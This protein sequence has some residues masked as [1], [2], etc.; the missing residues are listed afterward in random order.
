MPKAR[1]PHLNHEKDRHGKM[2]WYVRVRH[3]QRILISGAFGSAEFMDAYTRAVLVSPHAPPSRK[4]KHGT[5][6]H[7]VAEWKE[8]SDWLRTAPATRR[9]RENILLH[10]LEKAGHRDYG[11]IT[12]ADIRRGKEDR[13]GTPSAAN[14]FLKTM[15]ALFKWAVAE[16]KLD[17][18][19]AEGVP[20]F[21]KTKTGGFPTWT[22][23][24][25]VA[26][27]AKYPLGTRERLVMEIALNTGLRRSDIVRVGSGNVRKGV[28]DIK[29]AK[30]GVQ[31]YVPILPRL[32]EA[33]DA[34]GPQDLWVHSTRRGKLYGTAITKESLG[35][36]FR[37]WG[38]A[39]GVAK[40]L[41]GLR[42]L[43][44]TVIADEGAS[45]LE[46]QALFGWITNN[47][48]AVYTREANKKRLA[49]Q[50]AIRLMEAEGFGDDDDDEDEDENSTIR[51]QGALTL[52]SACPNLKKSAA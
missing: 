7:L 27:R 40:R 12:K 23:E 29:T 38:N 18:N 51:E 49:M 6:A 24:D 13:K 8:H 2:R 33:I 45:E 25:V 42:K 43:C 44:A 26:Y 10:V 19:P 1:L 11:E 28:I 31:L 36:L 17:E 46:L 48:S 5:L 4:A 41:H 34:V 50:A 3:G 21:P 30:T 47:Q 16:E 37:E 14:N 15:R 32:Q 35:T 20:L 39:A 52:R 22:I 9:Q